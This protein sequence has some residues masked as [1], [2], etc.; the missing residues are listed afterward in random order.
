[1][2][3]NTQTKYYDTII[4]FCSGFLSARFF[5]VNRALRMKENV[6]S[7]WQI[8]GKYKCAPILTKLIAYVYLFYF[9]CKEKACSVTS[10]LTLESTNMKLNILV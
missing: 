4:I 2:E 3:R 6:Q 7:F 8:M 10:S 9:A 5:K 1:M